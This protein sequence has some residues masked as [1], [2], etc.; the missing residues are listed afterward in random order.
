[1]DSYVGFN[2]MYRVAQ[3][4]MSHQTKCNFST[5]DTAF[6][7]QNIRG[8]TFQQSFKIS[9]KYFLGFKNYSFYNTTIVFGIFNVFCRKKSSWST[10]SW[11]SDDS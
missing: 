6:F 3:N 5:T 9:L 11:F 7:Y 8:K 10:I 2:V 1:M 4:K